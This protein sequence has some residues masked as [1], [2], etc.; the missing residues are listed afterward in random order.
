MEY[1][2][3]DRIDVDQIENSHINKFLKNIIGLL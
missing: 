2:E 3:P 1:G